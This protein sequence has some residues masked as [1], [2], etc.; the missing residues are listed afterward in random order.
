MGSVNWPIAVVTAKISSLVSNSNLSWKNYREELLWLNHSGTFNGNILPLGKPNL[1]RSAWPVGYKELFGFSALEF[2]SYL[3]EVK[4][5]RYRQFR[6]L[7]QEKKP[8][9]IICFGLSHW[10]EFEEIFVSHPEEISDY[11]DRKTKIY[12]RNRVILT[13]HFSNGMPDST[14]AFIAKQLRNWGVSLP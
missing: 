10:G 9:A 5:S 8:Q 12:E 14:V 13:R 3:D 11:P 1:K 2:N 4:H 6:E 7:R